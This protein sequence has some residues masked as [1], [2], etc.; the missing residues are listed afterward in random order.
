MQAI[1]NLWTS[2]TNPA[3][4]QIEFADE[5]KQPT[6]NDGLPIYNHTDGL[7]GKI[8]IAPNTEIEHTGVSIELIGELVV[9]E[10]PAADTKFLTLKQSFDIESPWTEPKELDFWFNSAEKPYESFSGVHARIKYYVKVSITRAG[11]PDITETKDF[12]VHMHKKAPMI[13][14]P[15]KLEVGLE[16]RL[17]I[18]FEYDKDTYSFNDVILGKIYFLLVRVPIKTMEVSLLRRETVFVGETKRLNIKTLGKWEL[19]DGSPVRGTCIPIRIFMNND[20][21]GQTQEISE[22]I[23]VQYCLNLVIVNEESNDRY[24]RQ[25]EIKLYR[26]K[27]E[28][29]R[30][31]LTEALE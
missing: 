23:S 19:M 14:T 7:S 24:F 27:E 30:S 4:I 10:H 8:N 15:I 29:K 6:D 1:R 28:S 2:F 20:N 26:S 17:H 22:K 31:L 16:N 12:I 21:M 11:R 3:D 13:E 5:D 18:E 9:F 25:H